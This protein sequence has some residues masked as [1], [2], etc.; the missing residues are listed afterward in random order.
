MP[1]ITIILKSYLLQNDS[2]GYVWIIRVYLLCA[3]LVPFLKKINLSKL[4][5]LGLIV[6][7]YILYE[8]ACKYR[9]LMDCRIIECTVYY[10]VPYGIVLLLGLNWK[11]FSTKWK[12]LLLLFSLLGF[13]ILQAL[14]FHKFGEYCFT[15]KYK[16]P[17]RHLFLM[18]AF[19]YIF[20]LMQFESWLSFLGNNKIVVFISK[21]TLWI[22]LWH[23]LVL[24]LAEKTI[25]NA[26]WSLK[27]IFV[28]SISLLIVFIQNKILDIIEMKRKIPILKIFRG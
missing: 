4:Y 9:V 19:L 8:V 18:H 6:L 25:P 21:S 5:T 7:T 22:Y 14:Y 11:R 1:G 24:R 28:L 26:H 12:R 10:L 16:Y 17:P 13:T 20:L 2:I 23:I 15:Q 3:F 27:Y